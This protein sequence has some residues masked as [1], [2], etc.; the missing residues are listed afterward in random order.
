MQQRSHMQMD[1]SGKLPMVALQLLA[2]SR[3]W[4]YARQTDQHISKLNLVSFVWS[5]NLSLQS[6]LAVRHGKCIPKKWSSAHV[7]TTRASAKSDFTTARL[8]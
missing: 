3:G 5:S 1:G 8:T 4:L 7:S 6:S 2:D